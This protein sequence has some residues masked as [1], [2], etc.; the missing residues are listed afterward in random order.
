M[1]SHLLFLLFPAIITRREEI[2]RVRLSFTENA[3]QKC[4]S[5]FSSPNKIPDSLTES[6]M[7]K[8]SLKAFGSPF[9]WLTECI[10]DTRGVSVSPDPKEKWTKKEE[11]HALPG[12]EL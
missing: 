8:I 3:P 7:I 6:L 2:Q 10:I 11:Q 5:T 4:P 1:I 12:A 9:R